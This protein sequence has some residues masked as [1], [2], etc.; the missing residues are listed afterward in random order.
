[1]PSNHLRI[2]E[3]FLKDRQDPVDLPESGFPF[4]TISRQTGAGSHLLCDRLLEDFRAQRS[5]LFRGWHVFDRLLCEAVAADPGLNGSLEELVKEHYKTEFQ[6]LM[7]SLMAGTPSHYGLYKRTFQVITMLAA[8]GKVIIVGRAGCCVTE[9]FCTGIHIRLVAPEAQ[10]LTA[11]MKRMNVSIDEARKIMKLK[12]SKR[13]RLLKAFFC[14][15]IDDPLLYDAV[16]NTGK[17]EIGEIS[18]SVIRLI[19]R[20]A[21]R[22]EP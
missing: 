14:R 17:A 20:R 7:D 18:D 4:V 22:S 6:D 16:W 9:S 21:G 19:E 3:R 15:S 10:R 13:R 5:D 12:E 1:M 11:T 8:I 2:V